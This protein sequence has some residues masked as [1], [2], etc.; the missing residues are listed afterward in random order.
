MHRRKEQIVFTAEALIEDPFRDAGSFGNLSC[1][2]AMS[3]RAEEV[4]RDSKHNIVGN[5]LVAPHA[6]QSIG[7]VRRMPTR[8]RPTLK[9]SMEKLGKNA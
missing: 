1:R 4:A 6:I 3:A 7:D 2:Y 9:P 8:H 5:R